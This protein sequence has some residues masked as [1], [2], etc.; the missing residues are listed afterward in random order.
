[1]VKNP[2]T[3]EGEAGSIPGSEISPRGGMATHSSILGEAHGERSPEG[4]SSRGRRV[5]HD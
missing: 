3:S 4:Y 2:P 1:M 5:G